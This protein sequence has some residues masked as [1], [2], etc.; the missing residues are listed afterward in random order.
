M[1]GHRAAGRCGGGAVMGYKNLMGIAV[2]GSQKVRV[3]HPEKPKAAIKDAMCIIK[4]A[5]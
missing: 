4:R 2:K 5:R 1:V 3:K